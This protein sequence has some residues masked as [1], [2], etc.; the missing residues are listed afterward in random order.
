MISVNLVQTEFWQA[1]DA[2]KFC[3]IPIT[4]QRIAYS[5]MN[6]ILIVIQAVGGIMVV[7][8]RSRIM[9]ATATK[10]TIGI[11]VVQT[12]FW[13]FTFAEN[14]YV[15]IRLRRHPTDA[16]QT[17][18]PHWKSYN[19]LFGLS[20]SIIGLGRNVMRLTMAGGIAF[21]IENEWA[22]YAFDG[23]QMVVVLGAWAIWYLPEKCGELTAKPTWTHLR[24]LER[25]ETPEGC[26]C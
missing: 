1:L 2:E 9:I 19:Q 5:T 10:L 23:Y 15:A 11:Y 22:S 12:F 26:E 7:A 25:R 20:I 24:A 4:W 3:W 21:L 17:L 8:S 6:G 14:I 13:A 16:S 18:L